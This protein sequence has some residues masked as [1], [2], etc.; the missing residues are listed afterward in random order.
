MS[1]DLDVAKIQKAKLREPVS[2]V[3]LC[4]RPKKDGPG[5]SNHLL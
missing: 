4:T 5:T 1:Q 2:S 3:D